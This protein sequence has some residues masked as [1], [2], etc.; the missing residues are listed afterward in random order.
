MLPEM[1]WIHHQLLLNLSIVVILDLTHARV[2]W[3]QRDNVFQYL[4]E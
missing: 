2:S 3:K 1:S 4:P